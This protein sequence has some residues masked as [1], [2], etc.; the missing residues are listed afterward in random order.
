MQYNYT[1]LRYSSSPAVHRV[2]C[3]SR[4]LGAEGCSP[5]SGATSAKCLLPGKPPTKTPPAAKLLSPKPNSLT[6]ASTMREAKG[7]GPNIAAAAAAELPRYPA[8]LRAKPA[9]LLPAAAAAGRPGRATLLLLLLSQLPRHF[10]SWASGM[11]AGSYR[12]QQHSVPKH[13][14]QLLVFSRG[15]SACRACRARHG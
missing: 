11:E 7:S 5:D 2:S 15:H 8:M 3:T 13:G 14:E 4:D 10:S 12:Q 6:F 1:H 9:L